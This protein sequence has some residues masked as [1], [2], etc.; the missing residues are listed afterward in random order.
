M[1]ILDFYLKPTFSNADNEIINKAIELQIIDADD[2]KNDCIGYI[3]ER[4]KEEDIDIDIE[5]VWEFTDENLQN[6]LTH[7]ENYQNFK[8]YLNGRKIHTTN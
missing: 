8:N 5:N 7:A 6:G 2:I 3:F 1:K 4:L